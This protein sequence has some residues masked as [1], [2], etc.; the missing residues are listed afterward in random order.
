MWRR[1]NDSAVE[2]ERYLSQ[3]LRNFAEIVDWL[4]MYASFSYLILCRLLT[5]DM[6]YKYM[7]YDYTSLGII[8]IN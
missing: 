4:E 8:L 3:F 1:L 6:I 5:L 2:V 7:D